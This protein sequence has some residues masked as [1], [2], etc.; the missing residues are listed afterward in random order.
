MSDEV[1]RI[2]YAK[3]KVII[4]HRFVGRSPRSK[5]S[6]K[7]GELK[8]LMVYPACSSFICSYYLQVEARRIVLGEARVQSPMNVNVHGPEP[9]IV[10]PVKSLDLIP[11]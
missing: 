7:V 6:H 10:K 9:V 4:R 1:I 2:I 5:I 3:C 11:I 8:N